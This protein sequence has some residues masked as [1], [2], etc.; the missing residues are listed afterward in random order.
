MANARVVRGRRTEV[1]I[2]RWL[3][4][5]GWPR[6]RSQWGSQPGKDI[7]YTPGHAIEVK[8]RSDFAPLKWL[9]QAKANAKPS[10]IPCVVVRFN[11]QGEDADNYLVFRRLEDDEL[12][13]LRSAL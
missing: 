3:R 1:V 6:A 9:R 5:H 11:G 13:K 4:E 12:N 8:A 2:A 10:E 7:R